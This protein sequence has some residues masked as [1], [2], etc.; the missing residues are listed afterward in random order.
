M[1]AG[2]LHTEGFSGE[3]WGWGEGGGSENNRPCLLAGGGRPTVR[4]ARPSS[5]A[6]IHK[7]G[8]DSVSIESFSSP[9]FFLLDTGVSSRFSNYM[10]LKLLV[11]RLK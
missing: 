2:V 11:S 7:W 6:S 4:N 1:K 8:A 9:V 3:G 10:F 5:G